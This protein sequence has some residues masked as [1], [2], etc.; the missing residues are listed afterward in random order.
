MGGRPRNSRN[1]PPKAN[2]YLRYLRLQRGFRVSD[3]CAV[4]GIPYS[5]LCEI[6]RG[7]R[8]PKGDDLDALG[9]FFLYSPASALLRE[10]T[11][12]LPDPDEG[13]L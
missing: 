3:V 1:H 13:T 5:T 9:R 11:V 4:T 8:L 6:E 7:E 12:T 2:T 10:V